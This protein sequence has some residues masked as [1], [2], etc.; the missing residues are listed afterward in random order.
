MIL[1]SFETNKIN[2]N[3][4]KYF[5]FYGKNEGA[6]S[7]EIFK[8]LKNFDLENVKKYD[9]KEIFENKEVF[10][11]DL[12]SKSLF[13]KEK[14][15]VVNRA[16]DK[17]LNIIEEIIDKDLPDLIIILN[18]ENLDKRSKLRSAF[19]KNKNLVCVPFYPDNNDTLIKITKSFFKERNI[20]ISQVNINLI[21]TR[22]NGDRGI[23]KNE[24]NKIEL[25]LRGKKNITT[26]NILKLTNLI[27]NYSISE[28]IDNCLAKNIKKTIE[29]LSEN[30]FN[31]DDC[32]EISRI[33]LNKSK[34]I[35]YLVN[36]FNENTNIEKT[37]SLAKPPIFWKDK[38]IV[39]KQILEWKPNQIKKLIYDLGEIE[40]QIKRNYSNSLNILSNF[41]L[42]KA[43]S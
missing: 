33:F 40:L 3:H 20:S 30:N 18:A 24:L 42:E 10:F 1:K 8:I 21:T 36:L 29:I 23:L 35:L 13:E 27:E 14:I 17:L 16:T 34:K 39:K 2:L 12:L 25:F 9:E 11:E 31:A 32:I 37:V 6:K 28:L 5:L 4:S 22:C 15:I 38:D 7:E 26:E 19:E 43:S 41:L